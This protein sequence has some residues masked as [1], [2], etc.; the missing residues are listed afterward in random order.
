MTKYIHTKNGGTKTEQKEALTHAQEIHQ[1]T[2][3]PQS[4]AHV[5]RGL[6]ASLLLMND[7][8]ASVNDSEGV[9]TQ[10]STPA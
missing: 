7:T 3:Y 1:A 6:L 5:S 8:P 10:I 2:H 9:L 4:G